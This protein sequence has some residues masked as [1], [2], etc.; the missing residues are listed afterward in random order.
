MPR[1][2]GS[3]SGHSPRERL[4][5]EAPLPILR[6][7][8][9]MIR[10]MPA[11]RKTMPSLRPCQ[12]WIFWDDLWHAGSPQAGPRR[13]VR[14]HGTVSKPTFESAL[15]K[16][17]PLFWRHVSARHSPEGQVY[18][19]KGFGSHRTATFRLKVSAIR[20]R[21]SSVCST[22]VP[23]WSGCSARQSR[24]CAPLQDVSVHGVSRQL[25]NCRRCEVAS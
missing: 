15:T 6:Q 4:P 21:A 10:I 24:M 17:V 16:E 18:C 3:S 25:S 7:L 12:K 5:V 13:G 19:A 22:G 8:G 20:G 9:C 23:A 2:S 14:A 11:L 1:H